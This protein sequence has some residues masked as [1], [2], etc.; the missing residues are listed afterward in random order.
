M[1]LGGNSYKWG[2][3]GVVVLDIKL[4]LLHIAYLRQAGIISDR[5]VTAYLGTLG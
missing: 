1:K 5:L 4:F 3:R 2:R